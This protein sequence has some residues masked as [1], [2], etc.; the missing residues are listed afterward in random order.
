MTSENDRSIDLKNKHSKL[1]MMAD[2]KGVNQNI[3]NDS[4]HGDVTVN[5]LNILGMVGKNGDGMNRKRLKW[6]EWKL[7]EATSIY[8]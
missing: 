3:T 1:T 2:Y 8:R 5:F 7:N 4:C 6:Y